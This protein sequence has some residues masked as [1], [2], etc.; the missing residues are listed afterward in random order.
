[1]L[2]LGLAAPLA[3]LGTTIIVFAYY[4]SGKWK[5]STVVNNEIAGNPEPIEG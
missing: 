5:V 4:L 3:S 1:M 2:G